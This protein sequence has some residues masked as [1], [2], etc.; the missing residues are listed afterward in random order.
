M[1]KTAHER[2]L[3]DAIRKA[4][5]VD[6]AKCY[7]CGKCTAGCPM[8]RYMDLAPNQIM[9]LVQVGD[10]AALDHLLRCAAIWSC[11]GCLT[12]TE[13][14]PKKLDPAAIMDGLREMS[15][16]RGMVS[17]RQKKVLAFHRAFL[18]LVEHT[19]RM[20]EM[21][22]T[23]LYK[24]TTGDFFSDV[25]LAP[26]MMLRGKLPLVPKTVRHRKEMRR[27]FAACRKGGER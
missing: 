18:K 25:T 1:A 6:V 22:L 7:Q 11:A 3:A 20:S 24:M 15:Y 26:A 5:G 9:R 2:T 23:G 17:A 8:A 16:R 21:P 14:C 27:L 4:T 12:C 13:R 10:A 19:G